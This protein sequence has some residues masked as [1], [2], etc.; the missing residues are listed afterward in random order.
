MIET[1]IQLKA[2]VR[3]MSGGNSAKAQVIIRN[4][5]MERFLER[6]SLSQY[7]NH[8]ILKG[9]VLISAMV[10]LNNRSTMDID[11]TIKGI[12]LSLDTAREMIEE[13]ISIPID[14]GMKFSLKGL[15]EVMEERSYVGL[16]ATLETKLD[17][18][19]IPLKIDIST[20][21]VITPKEI[22]Y[23]LKLM[24]EER[25]ISVMAYNLETVLAEKLE[26]IIS[27]GIAN[28]RLRDFYDIY[29]LQ[30]DYIQ[31]INKEKF[32]NAF[33]ETTRF[34][35]SINIAKNG[36]QI[37]SS[38]EHDEIMQN[39]WRNYQKKFDYAEN[40]SWNVVMEAVKILYSWT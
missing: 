30:V 3:N 19:R 1:A 29:I 18:M 33:L 40:I 25:S 32:G 36:E 9:G 7:K 21:D 39:L 26:T 8:F 2:L 11:T 31:E 6:V 14:D 10:G 22:S 38:I 5:A 15:N 34:R 35:D 27:R 20:G 13:I 17:N 37:I 23:E 28:T 16:S 4:Y 12:Y 24:F